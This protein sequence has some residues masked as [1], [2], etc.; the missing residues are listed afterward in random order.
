MPGSSCMSCVIVRNSSML[1]SVSVS[2]H[3]LLEAYNMARI[4]CCSKLCASHVSSSCCMHHA[5]MSCTVTPALL[6]LP[7]SVSHPL[8][9]NVLMCLFCCFPAGQGSAATLA[10]LSAEPA[11]HRSLHYL[12]RSGVVSDESSR[13]FTGQ[14]RKMPCKGC[15]ASASAMPLCLSAGVDRMR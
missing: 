11:G 2:E 13:S 15:R 5:C 4:D 7:R 12:G 8:P 10:A 9:L 3:T 1:V 6:L 14:L